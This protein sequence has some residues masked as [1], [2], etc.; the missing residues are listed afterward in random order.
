MSKYLYIVIDVNNDRKHL[1]YHKTQKSARYEVA[2]LSKIPYTMSN[3]NIIGSKGGWKSENGNFFILE[4]DLLDN[5]HS[6]DDE[7][8]E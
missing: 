1:S 2:I 6:Y 3:S 8:N 7:V 5:I 4:K